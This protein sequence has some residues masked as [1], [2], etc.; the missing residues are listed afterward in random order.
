LNN[1]ISSCSLF[2]GFAAP[3][4][5][6][7]GFVSEG[8][9]RPFIVVI[10]YFPYALARDHHDRLSTIVGTHTDGFKADSAAMVAL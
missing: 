5:F 7:R 2:E 8:L 1:S 9:V 6:S 10:R 3:V 4:N